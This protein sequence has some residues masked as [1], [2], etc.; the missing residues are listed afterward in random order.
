ME[1]LELLR[2]EVEVLRLKWVDTRRAVND[3][4][5]NLERLVRLE[6]ESYHNLESARTTLRVTR[7]AK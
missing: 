1:K 6:K 5:E 4:R 3:A 7:K 2:N